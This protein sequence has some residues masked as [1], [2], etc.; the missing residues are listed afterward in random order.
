MSPNRQHPLTLSLI[1]AGLCTTFG[2]AGQ[3]Y[4]QQS[5]PLA[6]AGTLPRTA[7]AQ[8]TAEESQ[9]QSVTVTATRREESLQ[10]VPLAVSVVSGADLEAANR[11]TLGALSTQVPSLNF[12]TGASNKDTSLFVRGVG[13]I[14]TSPGV[15]PTVSTVIDGVVLARPGQAT[16]DLLNV[17]RVEVLRGAQGTLFGKNASAGVVNITTL[18]PSKETEG[19]VDAS[20]FQGN[21]LR[22]RAGFSGTLGNGVRG[23]LN[24]LS[25]SYDG[26][27]TN[28]F[29]NSTANGYNKKGA[30]AKVQIDASKDVTVTLTA[31]VI[32]SRD[33]IPT[34]V[35]TRTSLIAFPSGTVTNY[36]AFATAIAPVL[37]SEDNRNINANLETR[38]EDQNRGVSAQVD[39]RVGSHTLTSITAWRGWDNT[40]YQDGDRLSKPAS[41]L[42]Q[43][44][45]KGTVAFKQISQELRLAS[46][47]GGTIDYVGGLYFLKTDNT[48]TYRRDVQRLGTGGALF[49]DYGLANY[50]TTSDSTALFGEGRWHF[51]PTARAI[52]GLR[53]TQ[54]S[55]SYD[56]KR[57]RSTPNA[58]FAGSLPGVNPPVSN[59]GSTTENGTTARLG[60]QWDLSSD[61][62]TYVTY[63]KGYK[64]PAYNVF[65]NMLDRDAL[66]LK[67]ET[68]NSVEWG[69][70]SE[71]L[72]KKLR[73]NLAAFATNY[74][75][76]QANF[77]DTVGGTVVTRLI[78]AGDVSTQGLEL[79]VLARASR[80]LTL[81][82]SAAYINARIDQFN[83]PVGAATSCAV[84]GKP[85]PFSPDWKL[86][87]RADYRIPLDGG[88]QINLSTDY[89]WQSEVQYDIGQ[90]AD[91]IQAAYGIWNASVALSDPAKG[92]RATLLVKNLTNQSYA[93]FLG[94]GGT[95]VNRWVPRDDQRYLGVNVR[96]DF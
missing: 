14:S 66:A 7:T 36:P 78:N 35:V 93:S 2:F 33:N 17:D 27:V 53:W 5:Q 18:A 26:N 65:F 48:E 28:V 76:Y 67:P 75:N 31:D 70:K 29:D 54:D 83:C 12:R 92:W 96:Y 19:Y 68:S 52:T 11:N 45:D 79:D 22:L 43:S 85:L 24:L 88:K 64:G 87:A 74:K 49:N 62:N 8:S 38:V 47:K 90:F 72:A 15:E 50:G 32:N 60:G 6:A 21:E 13:T 69:L 39:A 23:S 40:Q 9:L 63:S 94:R 57:E 20:L 3:T 86:V 55:L 95:Y 73:V 1:A 42:P 80:Q 61:V 37:A 16:L 30:R 34:G 71:L 25:A 89:N 10:N 84:N 82:G 81:S 58:Q 77:F 56:H 59:S 46:S 41:G 91:T 44:H 4:A 51:S